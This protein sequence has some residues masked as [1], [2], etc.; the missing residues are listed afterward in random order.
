[1]IAVKYTKIRNAL[2]PNKIFYIL[3]KREQPVSRLLPVINNIV[4]VTG[5]LF[6]Y[7]KLIAAGTLIGLN[8]DII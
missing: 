7:R 3:K 1:M 6:H 4:R 2:I 8:Q 5:R